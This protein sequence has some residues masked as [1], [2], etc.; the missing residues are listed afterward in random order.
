MAAEAASTLAKLHGQLLRGIFS[1]TGRHFQGLRS[2]A[3]HLRREELIINKLN[4]KFARI[5]DACALNRHVT[6]VSAATLMEELGSCLKPKQPLAEVPLTCNSGN[7]TQKNEWHH[8]A[9]VAS[10]DVSS[11]IH[12]YTNSNGIFMAIFMAHVITFFRTIITPVLF[13]ASAY[14]CL[15]GSSVRK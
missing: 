2:A 10:T 13:Q 4:K 3:A 5:G 12:G 11:G 1:K 6:V 14:P 15:V 7:H 9:E 8:A